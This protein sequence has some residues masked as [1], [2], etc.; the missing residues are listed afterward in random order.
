MESRINSLNKFRPKPVVTI[1][2]NHY[3]TIIT[4][5]LQ[6]H[7]TLTIPLMYIT[8]HNDGLLLWQ[9]PMR[10]NHPMSES[11]MTQLTTKQC[12]YSK[13]HLLILITV[14]TCF[15]IS[16]NGTFIKPAFACC[17]LNS[18]SWHLMKIIEYNTIMLL[19]NN[20][21]SKRL[22][23]MALILYLYIALIA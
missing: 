22:N 10:D 8:L 1:D 5:H 9:C 21:M 16:I 11:K 17:T 6:F 4:H 19:N 18:T 15:N 23:L 12:S 7:Y 14:I 13:A 2:T 20:I 3:I